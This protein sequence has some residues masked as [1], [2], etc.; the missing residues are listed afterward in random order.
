IE[1]FGKDDASV[2]E[3]TKLFATEVPEFSV[4]AR[5]RARGFDGSRSFLE[6]VHT[7]PTNVE[8]EATQTYTSPIDPPTFGA[9]GPTPTPNPFFTA[10]MRP[11]SA[12]VLMHYSMVKLPEKPMMPRLFDPRV[13][14]FSVHQQDFGQDEHRAPQRTYITRWRLEK[15]DPSA[16]LSEPVKPITYYVDPA[17]P[18]KWIPYVK[19]GIESWQ[20]AFEAAGFKKAIIAN[21][22]PSAKEDPDWSP[23][24]ARYSVVRWLP[25]TIE[26]AVGPHVSDPRTGEILDAD[27]QFY[28]NV[29][30]L[31][32]D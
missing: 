19:A 9:G 28:H 26:N 30:Q 2:I 4:R 18:S 29:M 6:S 15:K 11:G 14:Y 3:V 22:A 25:S 23:E 24:D 32:R 16:D 17:T 7:Y 20:Q 13:G 31:S 5:L 1:T 21:E 8:V 27:I 12:T 10:G